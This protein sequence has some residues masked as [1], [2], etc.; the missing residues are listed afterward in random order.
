MFQCGGRRK[1]EYL[2]P[3]VAKEAG[4]GLIILS[5]FTLSHEDINK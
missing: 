1:D 4:Q 5:K 2:L 3:A